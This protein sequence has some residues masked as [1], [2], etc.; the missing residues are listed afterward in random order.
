MIWGSEV[1]VT[2][3]NFAILFKHLSDDNEKRRELSS[4]VKE[5]V[6][7]KLADEWWH[8]DDDRLQKVFSPLKLNTLAGLEML[9]TG[10]S[11]DTIRTEVKHNNTA[12]AAWDIFVEGV[13]RSSV[14]LDDDHIEE[15]SDDKQHMVDNN[16]KRQKVDNKSSDLQENL[17]GRLRDWYT[18]E[19]SNRYD[20]INELL[21]SLLSEVFQL[22]NIE[23]FTSNDVKDSSS[24]VTSA[25]ACSAAKQT[26]KEFRVLSNFAFVPMDLTG[27]SVPFRTMFVM[28]RFIEVL[29]CLGIHADKPRSFIIQIISAR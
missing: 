16:P 3:K 29:E 24:S 28:Q 5:V 26:K 20:G 22:V 1:Y 10:K 17:K 27:I 11:I 6:G 25:N 2:E 4:L 12:L 7:K 18:E 14:G 8:S 13:N 19:F 9:R 15:E 23:H 21:Y